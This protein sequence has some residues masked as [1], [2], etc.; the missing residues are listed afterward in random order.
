MT[1]LPDG[2][3]YRV[4]ILGSHPVQYAAQFLHQLA[5]HPLVDLQVAYCSLFGAQ[6]GLDPEFGIEVQWDVP[7]LEG[8]PW[9]QIPNRSLRPGLGRFWGLFNPGLW[10]LIR[11]EHFDAIVCH[12]GYVFSSFW[13]AVAAAKSSGTPFLFG[14]DATTMR[15]RLAARWKTWVKPRVWR[16]VFGLAD[17]LL[18][19]SSGTVALFREM[20]F[21]AEKI[22]LTPFAVDNDWWTRQAALVNRSAVRASWDI[23]ENGKVILFC[24]KLQ[25]WKRPQ[26]VLRAFVQA[27]LPDTYVVFAGQG[28]LRADLEGEARERGISSRVRVLGFVNQSQLPATYRGAD[29]FVLPSEYDPCPVVVCEA[30]LCGLPV[31]LSDQIRGRFDLVLPGKTGFIYPCGD[32]NSLAAILRTLVSNPEEISRLSAAARERMKTWSPKE[33]V[34]GTVKAIEQAVRRGKGGL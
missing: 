15:P 27:N 2:R 8:Y 19:P 6:G 17:Q 5:Q 1:S 23:P 10:K 20:G 28:P 34:E 11:E 21:P 33:T 12:V 31:I 29:V 32:V 7:L 3:R 4:L 13:I 25:P 22:S 9:V 18:A 30:M 14:T 26:D 16:R 24:A